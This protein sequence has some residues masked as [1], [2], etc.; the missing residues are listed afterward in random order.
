MIKKNV[1]ASNDTQ[2]DH[3]MKTYEWRTPMRINEIK[4]TLWE[5]KS[6]VLLVYFNQYS[7]LIHAF[8]SVL[9]FT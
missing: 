9:A 7:I 1:I 4:I 6:L 8:L 3:K 2:Y 5:N